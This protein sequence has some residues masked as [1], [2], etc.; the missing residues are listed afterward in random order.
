M[1]QI[2]LF[3]SDIKPLLSNHAV[4][5]GRRGSYSTKEKR[6]FMASMDFYS[7][8]YKKHFST[9]EKGFDPTKNS[10]CCEISIEM[11]GMYT[12][13]GALSKKSGDLDGYAKYLIDAIFRNFKT[14]DDA[15][16]TELK[17]EKKQSLDNKWR[18]SIHLEK[19]NC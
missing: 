9:F 12:L 16:I 18:F 5:H 6:E 10:L 7:R 1:K 4:K 14:L 15:W 17:L 2:S 8:L 3:Y 19:L 13:K 11:P